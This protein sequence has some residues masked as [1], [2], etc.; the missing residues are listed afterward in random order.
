MG[1]PR[2]GSTPD[3]SSTIAALG[4]EE[5]T[6]IQREAIPPLLAGRDML[7]QAP[8][9]TGK[10]AAFALP[11][12]PADRRIGAGRRRRHVARWSSCPTRELAMQ[13]AEAVHRYGREMG[14][15]VAAGLRRPADRPAAPRAC[16]AASTSSSPRRAARSTTSSAAR[17]SSTACRSSC[18]TRPTRCSTWASPRTSR[19]S[20]RRRPAERQTAL[21]SATMP[22]R[23]ARIAKQHLRDPARVTVH[24]EKATRDGVAARPPGRLRRPPRPT[25]S[26][27]SAGSS[28]SRTRRRRSSSAG[29]AA[30][31]TS[32]PRR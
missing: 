29:P 10:T 30:R 6:P 22:P 7:G 32:S 26:P 31:S 28:T 12:A 16:G 18:S 11:L 17:S 13:V 3:S 20:S 27:R 24:A 8:T 14:V 15:R 5:P 1:S 9:G 2:S 21:F 4:Y 19:R 25:S 23:I